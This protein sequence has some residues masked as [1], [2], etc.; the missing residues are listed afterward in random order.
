MKPMLHLRVTAMALG[1]LPLAA[2]VS[3]AGS[4]VSSSDLA[5]CAA[6]VGADQRLACY[7]TLARHASVPSPQSL[8]PGAAPAA[9]AVTGPPVNQAPQNFGLTKHEQ[10]APA[11]PELIQARVTQLTT[12]R[13]GNVYVTLDN[14]QVWTF[15]EGNSA[16][17]AGDTVSIKHA[18]L[19]S[20]LLITADHHSYHARRVQ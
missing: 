13:M 9:A 8:A 4:S 17:R 19:G 1:F 6:I 10:T 11:Q 14:T 16:L 3:F 18:A 5:R 7:D 2:S 15:N 12:D 20:F